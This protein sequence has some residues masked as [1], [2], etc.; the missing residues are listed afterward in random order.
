MNA[1]INNINERDAIILGVIKDVNISKQ[2]VRDYFSTHDVSFTIRQY[3]RYL[4]K[5]NEEMLKDFA[6]LE[7]MEVRGC[8]HFEGVT[9][10][11]KDCNLCRRHCRVHDYQ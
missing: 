6:I 7:E 5:Y 11:K 4:K 2:T 1:S 10:V 9:V 8:Y 3:Y